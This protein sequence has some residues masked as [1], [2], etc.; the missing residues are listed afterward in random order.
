MTEDVDEALRLAGRV[1][2]W[3]TQDE[4]RALFEAAR[5]CTGRGVIVEI[6]SWKGKSTIFLARG[7]QLGAAVPVY[8]IDRHRSPRFEVFLRNIRRAGVSDLVRPIR[9][10]SQDAADDF[11]EPV[12]LLF[13]DG[14]HDEQLVRSDFD[15]W[16]PKVIEGGTVAFHDTTWHS[17]PRRVVGQRLYRSDSFS[18]VRFVKSS[19]TMGRKVARNTRADR[20]RARLQLGRKTAFWL[21][22]LPAA[23]AR[24]RL[25]RSLRRLGRRAIG[26]GGSRGGRRRE[27][28]PRT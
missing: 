19:L 5:G 1:R 10:R 22:T 4:A 21:V 25:P 13:V 2:G 3:L 17:G 12:E 7:S 15:K 27:D 14:A 8:A 18:D 9:A 16:V 26:L 6:G 11:R 23:K 28:D 20:T 24:H